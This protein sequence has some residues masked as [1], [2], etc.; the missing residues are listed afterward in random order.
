MSDANLA[1]MLPTGTT[2]YDDD[3]DADPATNSIIT[4]LRFI[5][6]LWREV[7]LLISNETSTP[8]A[9]L[10]GCLLETII[11]PAVYTLASRRPQ[12]FSTAMYRLPIGQPGLGR[13]YKRKKNETF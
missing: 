8:A 5:D 4:L 10:I 11:S 1:Q 2:I 13:K 6:N 7:N 9:G 3:D 12:R